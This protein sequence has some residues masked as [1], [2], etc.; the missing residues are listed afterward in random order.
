MSGGYHPWSVCT[1]VRVTWSPWSSWT[2]WAVGPSWCSPKGNVERIVD[3]LWVL[4]QNWVGRVV[5]SRYNGSRDSLG[6]RRQ[7]LCR[8]S[9]ATVHVCLDGSSL[10][11]IPFSVWASQA[12]CLDNCLCASD[13]YVDRG[14]RFVFGVWIR[15]GWVDFDVVPFVI[16]LS[17]CEAMVEFV[18]PSFAPHYCCRWVRY[19]PTK[20]AIPPVVP[21]ICF[22][23]Q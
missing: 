21:C 15:R 11:F 13:L 22:A 1:S 3:M 8:H 7:G 20:V 10:S 14:R 18:P 17:G 5:A 4:M 19:L 16:W 23:D 6:V 12:V 9:E 2:S